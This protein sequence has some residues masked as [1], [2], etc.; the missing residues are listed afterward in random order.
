MGGSAVC[1]RARIP[2]CQNGDV[3]TRT[4]TCATTFLDGF[5]VVSSESLRSGSRGQPF[6]APSNRGFT[7]MT[8]FQH[9]VNTKFS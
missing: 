1:A 4:S 8:P 9:A 6:S 3:A 2:R 5:L 7:K